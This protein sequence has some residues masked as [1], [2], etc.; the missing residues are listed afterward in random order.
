VTFAVAEGA[1]YVKVYPDECA[2][3]LVAEAARLAWARRYVTV[4][5]VLSSGPGWLHTAGLPARSADDGTFVGHVDLAELGVTADTERIA[6]YR[7]SWD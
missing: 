5:E 7:R 3:L 4:P 6:Y 1:E 2:G